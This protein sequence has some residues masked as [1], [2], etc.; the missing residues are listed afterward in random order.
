MS[1][2]PITITGFAGAA[3]APNPRQLPENVGVAILDAEPGHGDL[4]PM[5]GPNTVATV[6]ASPQ[7]RTIYRMGR[8]TPSETLYWLAWP[9]LVSV[10]RGFDGS[11]P[12]ERTYFSG[13]GSPKWTDNSIGLASGPPYP[14][15]TREL[16]VPAPL[17][18]L[19]VAL[20]TDGTTGTENTNFYVQTFGNDLGWESAPGPI[21][22]GVAFKPGAHL[23]IGATIPMELAPAG[24]YGITWRRIYRT[25][26][27]SAGQAE[28]FFLREVPIGTTSTTDDARGL[29]DL[30]TTGDWLS[31]PATGFG[32]IALWGGMTAM[33]DGK[34]ILFSEVGAPYAYPDRFNIA[35]LDTPLAT[36]AW[37]QTL[38]VLT[39]GRPVVCQGTGPDSMD[40]S[41]LAL[42]QPLAS[43]Q[44][45]VSFGHGVAWASNEG[46][47]YAGATGQ[48]VL[49]E[50]LVTPRQWKAM[51]PDTMVAGRY[52]RFYVCSYDDG[53]G[54]RAFMIDPKAPAGM[55]FLSSGW[56]AAF[57]DE[58]ANALY[59][60]DGGNIKRF[61]SNDGPLL[62]ARFVSKR[63]MQTRPCN[64]SVAKVVATTYPVTLTITARWFSPE[65]AEQSHIEVRSV[66]NDASFPLKSGFLAD[67]WQVE[68]AAAGSVQAVRLAM[69]TRDMRGL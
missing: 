62:T 56:L 5:R 64:F 3:L 6:S 43:V 11:D 52:G 31:P 44:S 69:D 50:G 37:E 24:N 25:Q 63:F 4:R 51:R 22:N 33:L 55:W 2:S 42:S 23:S 14:Q 32:L 13:S 1:Q 39:T 8:D 47:A 49:T 60:L 9:A 27:D 7:R 38:L 67:D 12:T 30:L 61:D 21:S 35:T 17:A 57:Y 26:A 29:A 20:V 48:M 18:P 19:Q 36:A 10:A 59:V 15:G 46:L 28:F 66:N 41:R 34:R 68:I 53:A 54:R 58:L 16:A 45:V 65:G 40:D